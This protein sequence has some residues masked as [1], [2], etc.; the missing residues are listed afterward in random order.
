[1]NDF[2][3]TQ[4]VWLEVD[5]DAISHTGKII[6]QELLPPQTKIMAVLKSDAYGL[7]ATYL[8][9]YLEEK[10]LVDW[11]AVACISEA[12]SLRKSGV[13]KPILI[14]GKDK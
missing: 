10:E 8:A 5:L 3:D 2:I 11:F 4:R 6:R 12:I 7:G 13:T 14:L 9:T 1:M